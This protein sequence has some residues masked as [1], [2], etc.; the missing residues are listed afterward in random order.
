[1]AEQRWTVVAA[2]TDVA[3]GLNEK[4]R[5]LHQLLNLA[6][7]RRARLRR[8]AMADFPDERMIIAALITRKRLLGLSHHPFGIAQ[9]H[10]LEEIGQELGQQ[11][12]EHCHDRR[13]PTVGQ[14]YPK[15]TPEL[16]GDIALFRDHP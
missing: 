4:R 9:Q 12:R 8:S 15:L 3:S 2:L 5:G 10:A 14:L 16:N 11:T 13:Q 6:Q 7:E 1:M